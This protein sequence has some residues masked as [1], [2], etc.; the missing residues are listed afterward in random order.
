MEWLYEVG[1][2][3]VKVGYPK[4]IAQRN[5]DFNNAHVWTYNYLLKRISEVS[6]EYGITVIYVN[7]AHTSQTC[8]IHGN[9]CGVRIRRGLFKCTTLNKA[10]N[11]DLVGA[12]N[13][14]ITPSP[15][16]DRGNGLETPPG[17]KPN[18][19]VAPNLPALTGT[20]VL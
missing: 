10:P 12:Y 8:P 16:R 6:E 9:G 5:G 20:P 14:L 19:D 4:H 3:T 1:V 18:R 2:S 11:A 15:A 7:E 17:A 13:V